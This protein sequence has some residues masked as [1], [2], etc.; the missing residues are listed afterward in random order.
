YAGRFAMGL[1]GLDANSPGIIATQSTHKQLASFSQAS[2]IHVRDRHIKGQ[3][4]RVEHR[5]FNESFLQHASTSPFYPIFA[6]LDVGAQ[7]MKGRSGIILWDDTVRL[8]IE[9]RKKLRAIRRE[10]EQKET[11]PARRWF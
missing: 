3:R 10:Y 5:R 1:S 9:I 8:G 7:M 6:S 11:D 4:R 2:Q